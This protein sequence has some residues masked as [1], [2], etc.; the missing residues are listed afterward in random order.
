MLQEEIHFLYRRH[1]LLQRSLE[2]MEAKDKQSNGRRTDTKCRDGLSAPT[3]DVFPL[4]G[5]ALRST[6]AHRA[7]TTYV[8]RRLLVRAL[9]VVQIEFLGDEP[10]IGPSSQLPNLTNLQSP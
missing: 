10:L 9:T 5:I 7:C 8:Y 1:R 3:P 6:D 2:A 4:R